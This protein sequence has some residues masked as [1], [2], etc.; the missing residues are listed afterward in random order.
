LAV[1]RKHVVKALCAESGGSGGRPVRLGVDLENFAM[2]L[3][4]SLSY[5]ITDLKISQADG[6][7]ILKRELVRIEIRRGWVSIVQQFTI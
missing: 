2:A 7:W 1:Q 5:E 4:L 6:Q 3:K